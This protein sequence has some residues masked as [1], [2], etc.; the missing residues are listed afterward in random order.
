MGS[1][2]FIAAHGIF[3]CDM[4]TLNF[5][6]WDLVPWLGIEPG[7]VES[8]LLDHQGSLSIKNDFD[9]KKPQ[10]KNTK[11]MKNIL[12]HTEMKSEHR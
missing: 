4:G 12:N 8:K 6:V 1:S 10:P 2:I 7:S 9:C 5:G 11:R 3:S